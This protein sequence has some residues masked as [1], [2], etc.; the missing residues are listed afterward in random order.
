MRYLSLSLLLRSLR[1]MPATGFGLMALVSA[2]LIHAAPAVSAGSAGPPAVSA[3]EATAASAEDATL[4][5]PTPSTAAALAARA[6]AGMPHER[7][8][9][10][11]AWPPSLPNAAVWTR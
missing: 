7:Q 1:I 2:A 4:S 6:P 9:E 3:G 8:G 10:R 5:E 11:Q